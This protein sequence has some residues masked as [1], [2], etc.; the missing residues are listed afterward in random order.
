MVETV[1]RQVLIV[2]QDVPKFWKPVRV[3]SGK[4]PRNV[5]VYQSKDPDWWKR[6]FTTG[7]DRA[8][9]ETL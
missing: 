4:Q 1:L 2:I 7:S 6:H 3:G 8:R 5:N 9:R